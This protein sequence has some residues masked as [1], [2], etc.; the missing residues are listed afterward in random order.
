MTYKLRFFADFCLALTAS[1]TLIRG[2]LTEEIMDSKTERSIN[3]SAKNVFDVLQL[4]VKTDKPIGVLE[5]GRTLSLPPSSV[6][7]AL[8]SLEES[9]FASRGLDMSKYVPGPMI[10]HLLRAMLNRYEVRQEAYECINA[11]AEW[12]GQT[13][14]LFVRLGWY[15]LLIA[16]VEGSNE[17]CHARSA[18]EVMLL[19]ET[20]AGLVILSRM[21]EEDIA[22]MRRFIS[23]NK[24]EHA[25]FA[26]SSETDKMIEEASKTEFMMADIGEQEKR[27]VI[28]FPLHN[29]D[30]IVWASVGISGPAPTNASEKKV[31]PNKSV[32]K[33]IRKLE[34]TLEKDLDTEKM[35]F[36]HI[37]PDNIILDTHQSRV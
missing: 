20:P 11:I 27:S 7:R 4:L 13:T 35:P 17:V 28:A 9:R 3:V 19:N 5:I 36:S 2:S 23:K 33:L 37:H 24:P 10:H 29:K 6:H 14:S 22:S 32:L 31:I 15:S 16:T 26:L 34:T 12:S 8:V 21:P 1:Q 18:G 25:E 30:K